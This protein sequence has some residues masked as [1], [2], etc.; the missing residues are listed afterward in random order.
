MLCCYTTY[1]SIYT[2]GFKKSLSVP[3][4]ETTKETGKILGNT[5]NVPCLINVLLARDNRTLTLYKIVKQL[6]STNWMLQFKYQLQKP[7]FSQSWYSQFF[8]IIYIFSVT[9]T[10]LVSKHKN[11]YVWLFIFF[12]FTACLSCLFLPKWRHVWK[13]KAAL[14]G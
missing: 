9:Q 10:N 1:I 4:N 6:F 12:Q 11:I 7:T 3:K 13:E 5:G 2:E 14:M 8:Q